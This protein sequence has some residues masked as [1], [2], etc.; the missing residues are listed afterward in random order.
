VNAT[1]IP[2]KEESS[3][4]LGETAAKTWQ[5]RYEPPDDPD[6]VL[7]T[8]PCPACE[9]TFVYDWPLEVVR[10]E[11]AV[12]KVADRGPVAAESDEST[13]AITVVCRCQVLH[14]G[15][16]GEPGCGRSWTLNI[17]RP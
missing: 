16:N 7:L 11:V 14:P 15:S 10:A 3:D 6:S 1:P 13:L 5:Y 8:G 4:G 17:P 9:D 2:Y 12:G